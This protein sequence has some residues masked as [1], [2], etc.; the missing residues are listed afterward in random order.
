[1][2]GFGLPS[3]R[4]STHITNTLL[5]LI[6]TNYVHKIEDKEIRQINRLRI[7]FKIIVI[8]LLFY[9]VPNYIRNPHS[10]FEI[11]ISNMPK[12]MIPSIEQNYL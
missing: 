6:F 9:V 2:V 10:K 5:T 3:L 8:G 4:F 11:D 1:M 7:Y 12:L